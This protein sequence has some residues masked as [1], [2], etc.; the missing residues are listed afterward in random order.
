MNRWY[1]FWIKSS[2]GTDCT[3]Y[4][5]LPY[6]LSEEAIKDYLEEWCSQFGAWHVSDN[7]VSYGYEKVRKPPARKQMKKS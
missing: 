5:Q 1:R 7:H 3:S 4:V 6:R 2:R